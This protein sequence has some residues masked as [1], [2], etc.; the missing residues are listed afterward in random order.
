MPLIVFTLSLSALLFAGPAEL[1][2]AAR[3]NK[4]D[5]IAGELDSGTA[6]ESRSEE[7]YTALALAAY[8]GKTEA[9]AFLIKRGANLETRQRDGYTPLIIA[10]RRNFPSMLILLRDSGAD[11]DARANN[12][13]TALMLECDK[14]G[15][16]ETISLLAQSGS[17][18]DASD[19][20]GF[21]ALMRAAKEGRL[22]IVQLLL[23][24]GARLAQ[25]DAKGRD[26]WWWAS[27]GGSDPLID[28]L[29]R[30][31]GAP[32]FP[33][34]PGEF[35]ATA[36]GWREG[37]HIHIF[38]FELAA[39]RT[40]GTLSRHEFPAG[41]PYPSQTIRSV[42]SLSDY[43]RVET[44][45]NFYGADAYRLVLDKPVTTTEK[46]PL[47]LGFA[48]DVS[49]FEALKWKY[50]GQGKKLPASYPPEIAQ[51]LRTSERYDI[52]SELIRR[53]SARIRAGNPGILETIRRVWSTV[54]GGMVY[55][56]IPRPNTGSQILAWGKGKCGDFTRAFIT[57]AR[58]CGIP[59]RAV[60]G[61]GEYPWLSD[62]DHAWAEVYVNGSG[63]LPVQPQTKPSELF[64]FPVSFQR[65]YIMTRYSDDV[66]TPEWD[67]PSLMQGAGL[68]KHETPNG[69]GIFVELPQAE[70]KGFIA[71]LR[72]LLEDKSGAS[73]TAL[74]QAASMSTD[75]RILLLWLI[76]GSR[77][78]I[79]A[80]KA[81]RALV[82][83]A[84]MLADPQAELLAGTTLETKAASKLEQMIKESPHFVR[85]RLLLAIK[86]HASK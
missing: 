6:M 18:L 81:A 26:A 55:A 8:Y 38:W 22:D 21:S 4:V 66:E 52:E 72:L 30:A 47:Y 76:A 82:A 65:F 43:E 42:T 3:K 41:V 19:A 85:E 10:A 61:L 20:S 62:A 56:E 1:L 57:L 2:D 24:Q 64:V 44:M 49:V 60:W 46:R 15:V 73:S 84:S 48:A 68:T 74:S 40:A 51:Y 23:R 32:A 69:V 58:S 25:R 45:H 59:S 11:L 7:G 16:L 75:S 63:W 28:T 5:L 77:D 29:R 54:N 37:L 17:N 53:E 12:G 35:S 31:S 39:G 36:S 86:E 50:T 70:R 83:E 13:Y 33:L 78:E 67:R 71:L 80:K 27:Y 14:T 79:S 9:A 34:P